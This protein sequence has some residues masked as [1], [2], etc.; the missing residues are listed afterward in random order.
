MVK[1]EAN[2]TAEST[3]HLPLRKGEI[4]PHKEVSSF[5]KRLRQAV[6]NDRQALVLRK[7]ATSLCSAICER[8]ASGLKLNISKKFSLYKLCVRREM[9]FELLA[10][11]CIGLRR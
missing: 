8:W 7:L 1:S 10:I 5:L 9:R 11:T 2:N 3:R 4:L 6:A